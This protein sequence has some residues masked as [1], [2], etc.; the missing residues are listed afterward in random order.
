M[1]THQYTLIHTPFFSLSHTQ[2][3]T[4]READIILGQCY[5]ELINK[6]RHDSFIR[7]MTHSYVGWLIH[8]WPDSFTCVLVHTWRVSFHMW[9]DS[10]ICDM[11][12]SCV[13][14]PMHVG[15]D[16]L[17]CDMTHSHVTHTSRE[18]GILWMNPVTYELVTLCMMS[19]HIW[20]MEYN[21]VTNVWVISHVAYVWVI[22]TW[23]GF[24]A[25]C[26]SHVYVTWLMHSWAT[27]IWGNVIS[28]LS[29]K[30]DVMQ[31]YMTW[32]I[33]MWHDSCICDMTHS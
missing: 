29:T 23:L 17:I 1:H 16:S 5:S 3:H 28:N 15:H 25:H 11:T 9:H 31:S 32:L 13:P 30:C 21:P 24:M 2:I 6:M 4:I 33:H 10:F 26:R 7:G 12:Q 27:T 18:Y 22:S 14:W 20:V 8:T 19:C